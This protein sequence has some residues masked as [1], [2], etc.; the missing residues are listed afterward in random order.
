MQENFYFGSNESYQKNHLNNEYF[1]SG[2]NSEASD[3]EFK[4]PS[5]HNKDPNI[6]SKRHREVDQTDPD[7]LAKFESFA[8]DESDP[9]EYPTA[10]LP[11]NV[12]QNIEL[13]PRRHVSELSYF[14]PKRKPK[15]KLSQEHPNYSSPRKVPNATSSSK[16]VSSFGIP[17]PG[18]APPRPPDPHVYAQH[19]YS[20]NNL[21]QYM[22]NMQMY[23]MQQ[24]YVCQP[25]PMPIPMIYGCY[26]Y[27]EINC[28]QRPQRYYSSTSQIYQG[29][30]D[31]GFIINEASEATMRLIRDYERSGDY[32]KLAGKIRNLAKLQSGSRFLQKELD[33]ADNKFF[34]F[35]LNEVSYYNNL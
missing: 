30:T 18:L 1:V 10:P 19:T 16:L 6:N 9:D 15:L 4:F 21:N 3:N 20:S 28:K 34:D 29:N 7:L 27:P 11:T 22:G 32:T 13:E 2:F 5:S 17:P 33:K 14:S 12:S 8:L 26:T 35:I 31:N 25:Q 23:P 24:Y